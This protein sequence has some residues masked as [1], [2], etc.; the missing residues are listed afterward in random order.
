M[1]SDV[2]ISF[3]TPNIWYDI[4]KGFAEKCGIFPLFS[5]IVTGPV[6]LFSL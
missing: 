2:T 4:D 3:R 1:T 5:E 6:G